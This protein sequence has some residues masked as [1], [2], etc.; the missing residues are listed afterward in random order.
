VPAGSAINLVVSSGLP[1]VAVPNVVGQSQ[2][3][4]TDTLTLAGL[5]VGNVS[6]S[7]STS[8]PAGL[9]MAQTP[10][11]SS[12]VP[13][14][15]VV[16]LVIS[17]GPPDATTSPVVDQALFSD[18]TGTRSTALFSTSSPNELLL[19]FV[20]SDGPSSRPQTVTVSGAGLTWTLVA[21]ANTQ[22]GTSE[23]WK[24]T[25]PAVLSN[26]TVRSVQSATGYPQ[27]LAVL[28]FAGAS[29]TGAVAMDAAKSAPSL[30]LT[31]TRAGSVIYGVG[32]DMDHNIAPTPA[33]GQTVVHQFLPSS[34]NTMWV[35]AYGDPVAAAG[36]TVVLADTAPTTDRWN[37]VGVEIIR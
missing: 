2:S 16:A 30:S 5:V 20:A 11:A 35:Q 21:R 31:T 23:I 17:S 32:N 13:F 19:A 1:V 4:A 26:V 22:R 12:L 18:G 6:S 15:S 24:A 33:S 8:V 7:P 29:G 28:T 10:A 14:G 36:S 25:A 9:V 37:F 27:T 34:N 3:A